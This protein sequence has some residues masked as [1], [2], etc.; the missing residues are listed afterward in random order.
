[1][2]CGINSARMLMVSKISNFFWSTSTW[3]SY[4]FQINIHKCTPVSRHSQLTSFTVSQKLNITWL[5]HIT[6]SALSVVGPSLSLVRR[7]GTHYRTVRDPALSSNSF[8]QSLKTN[9][10][11]RYNSAHTAQ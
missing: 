10:F 8:R 4:N 6:G 1:M 2:N 9:L 5:C 11:R 7:S 3:Q